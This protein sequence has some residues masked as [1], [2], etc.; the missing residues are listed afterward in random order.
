MANI[1]EAGAQPI[2]V[3]RRPG[4]VVL[5]T[6]NRRQALNS[7]SFEMWEA[8]S[9]A[10]DALERETP[11]RG[12]IITGAGGFFSTG[13]DVKLP[14]ARGEG[15]LAPAARLELGQRIIGRLRRLPVPV[16][17]AVEGGAYGMGW[18]LALAADLLFAAQDAKFGAPFLDYGTVPDGG[19][20]WFLE[21][22]IGRLR[23]AELV[24]SGSSID[25]KEAFGVGLVSR[26]C[27]PGETV[28]AA[29]AFAAEIGKGNRQAAE[30][31]KRLLQQA[32]ETS[33][34]ASLAL[35]LAHC[36]ICQTGDEAARAREQ[37]KARAAARSAEK[38]RS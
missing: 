34:E 2:L 16:I 11:A 31:A 24:F 9:A 17:A 36:A 22:Q 35:E 4:D 26:L 29:L 33:L 27:P 10:L 18:G 12:L 38:S 5:I 28:A 37:F 14:P 3:E 13:G 7:V 6:L 19:S 20:A 8:F 15:A 23:A 32:S 25:A 30:L 21:R 1:G